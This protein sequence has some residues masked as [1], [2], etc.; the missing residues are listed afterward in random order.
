MTSWLDWFQ[1]ISNDL[2][3]VYLVV[4]VV[5]AFGKPLRRRFETATEST[6]VEEQLTAIAKF[7]NFQR[8]MIEAC[9]T[10]LRAGVTLDGRPW[11]DAFLRQ[12]PITMESA[13]TDKQAGEVFSRGGCKVC[14]VAPTG[15]MASIRP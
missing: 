1:P 13:A 3:T 7:R 12:S 11:S 6:G 4:L 14:Q 2:L 9:N 15:I 5:S 8:P 10:V